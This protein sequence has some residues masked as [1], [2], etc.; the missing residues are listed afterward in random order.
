[1]SAF[2]VTDPAALGDRA[3]APGVQLGRLR[4]AIGYVVGATPSTRA[5]PTSSVRLAVWASTTA[6]RLS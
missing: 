4:E 3:G 1:M 6:P 2:G 5:G